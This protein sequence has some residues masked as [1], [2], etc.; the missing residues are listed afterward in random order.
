[1]ESVN[2]ISL[3]REIPRHWRFRARRTSRNF[4]MQPIPTC[5]LS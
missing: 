5:E 1:V 4:L 3:E 2:V